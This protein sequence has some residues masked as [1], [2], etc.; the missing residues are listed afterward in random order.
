MREWTCPKCGQHHH[1]D[2]NAA[3]N[4]LNKGIKK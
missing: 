1:R 2:V 3:K 4:I